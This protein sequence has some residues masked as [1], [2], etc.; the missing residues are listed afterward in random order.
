MIGIEARAQ[1]LEAERRLPD[2]LVACVGGGS[3]S[4]GLFYPFLED[5][6]VGIVGV[7]A[8]GVG[9]G[10]HM[11][12]SSLSKGTPGVLHGSLSYLLQ[13]KDGQVAPTHSIAAGLDYPGVGPEHSYLKETGRVVY[14]SVT[15]DEAVTAFKKLSE[16]EGIIPALE[17]SHALAYIMREAGKSIPPG[18]TVLLCLSGRGDKDMA[19]IGDRL[20]VKS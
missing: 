16:L 11:H 8:G 15:D 12:C 1:I 20:G 6:E 5:T 7:E 13:D 2:L 18:H 3:N 4:I 14:R 17:P 19:T 10:T 9:D